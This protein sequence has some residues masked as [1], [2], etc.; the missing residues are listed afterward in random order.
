M[1]NAPTFAYFVIGLP[2]NRFSN[3]I[4]PTVTCLSSLNKHR[5][6]EH[7]QESQPQHFGPNIRLHRGI[8]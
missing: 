2:K 5:P 4:R 7:V 1:R 6:K 3:V 8:S